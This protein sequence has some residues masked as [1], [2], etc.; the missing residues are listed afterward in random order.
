MALRQRWLGECAGRGMASERIGFVLLR[1]AISRRREFGVLSR[2][3]QLLSKL[4]SHRS[5]RPIQSEA[6]SGGRQMRRRYIYLSSTVAS[7]PINGNLVAFGNGGA[8]DS[9]LRCPGSA[10]ENASVLKNFAMG[11]DG[12]YQLQLRVEFYNLFNRHYYAINGCGGDQHTQVGPG[13]ADTFG[14]VTGV[15]DNPRTGQFGVRFTF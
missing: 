7:S 3:G 12:Q 6:I 9:G 13:T 2:L 8:Y 10:N 15:N 11:S 14:L 5:V 4:Q 1:A